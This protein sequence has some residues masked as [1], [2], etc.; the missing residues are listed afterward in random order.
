MAHR[1]TRYSMTTM[2]KHMSEAETAG[3]KHTNAKK[4]GVS[5]RLVFADIGCGGRI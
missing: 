4:P 2:Q 5:A 1:L 3:A